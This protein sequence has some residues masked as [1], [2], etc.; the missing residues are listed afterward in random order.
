MGAFLGVFSGK[1]CAISQR[2]Q[3][4]VGTRHGLLL[5]VCQE[6]SMP[7]LLP[8]LFKQGFREQKKMDL[9]E[10]CLLHGSIIEIMTRF[11]STRGSVTSL[12]STSLQ[13]VGPSMRSLHSTGAW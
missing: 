12:L 9:L 7:A 11:A 10:A 3:Q 1:S 5:G 6:L 2:Q 13:E 4:G 8:T